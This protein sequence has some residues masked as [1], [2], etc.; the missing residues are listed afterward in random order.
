MR[1]LVLLLLVLNVFYAGWHHQEL[2][3]R[4]KELAPLST[5]KG[6]RHHIQL[7]NEKTETQR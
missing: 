4:P 3:V 6:E 7:L 2:P 1:W 5:Y